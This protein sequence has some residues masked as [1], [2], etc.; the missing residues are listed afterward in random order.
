MFLWQQQKSLDVSGRRGFWN[1]LFRYLLYCAA[2]FLCALLVTPIAAGLSVASWQLQ[3]VQWGQTIFLMI[4]PPVLWTHYHLQKSVIATLRLQRP[5]LNDVWWVLCLMICAVPLL[6]WLAVLNDRLPLPAPLE[7][8]LR[9]QQAQSQQL[10]ELMLGGDNSL[11]TW[12]SLIALIS[13]GTAIGEELMFRGA[14]LNLFLSTRLPRWLVALCIGFLFSAIHFDLY[15]FLPR[16][17][18]GT[19][20][21]YLVYATGSLWPSIIAHACNN[22]FALIEFRCLPQLTDA[23]TSSP[24][25]ILLSGVVTVL[26]AR[27]FFRQVHWSC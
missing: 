17:I 10:M 8:L 3:V 15:G 1:E 25:T 19:F 9:G 6:E 20:F 18:L 24:W 4:L 14:L 23:L 11:L 26:L 7:T 22:L 21:V 2:G 16:W 27:R 13:V 12:C 5:A